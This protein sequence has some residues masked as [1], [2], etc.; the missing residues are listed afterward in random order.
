MYSPIEPLQNSIKRIQDLDGISVWGSFCTVR[1][2]GLM[3][4]VVVFRLGS[5]T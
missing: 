5:K 1:V 2:S 4:V 3:F